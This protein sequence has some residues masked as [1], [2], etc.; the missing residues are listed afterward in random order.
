M[1]IDSVTFR[2]WSLAVTMSVLVVVSVVAPSPGVDEAAAG[3]GL[4]A[5]AI[6]WQPCG[7]ELPGLECAGVEVHSI[8]ARAEDPRHRSRSLV[9]R[10]ADPR[11]RLKVCS[12]IQAVPAVPESVS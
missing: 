1:S 2:R 11:R 8:T 12:S 3:Q 4:R 5:P 10:P 9:Y 6:D 7:E